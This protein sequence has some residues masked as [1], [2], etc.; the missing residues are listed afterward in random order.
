MPKCCGQVWSNGLAIGLNKIKIAWYK[1][2]IA[3]GLGDKSENQ[4]MIEK[5]TADTE[6]R[7]KAI[8]ESAKKLK[9]ATVDAMK[10]F[11]A[12]VNSLHWKAGETAG[13]HNPLYRVLHRPTSVGK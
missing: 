1:F 5:L 6:K 11:K 4:K 7:A 2:K 8:V 12:G 3:V 9:E 10:E 13:L